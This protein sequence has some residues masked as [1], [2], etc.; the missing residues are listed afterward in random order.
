L[1]T[2]LHTQDRVKNSVK[3]LNPDKGD[4]A[5]LSMF[6]SMLYTNLSGLNPLNPQ[7]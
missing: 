7:S 3:S 5:K 4:K 6:E 2:R 1:R